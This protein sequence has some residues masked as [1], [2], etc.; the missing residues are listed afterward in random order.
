MG[1]LPEAMVNFLAPARLGARRRRDLRAATSSSPG[2]TSTGISPSPSRFN[3]DKLKWVNQEHLKRLSEAELGAGS[4][5][6]SRGP[7]SISAA[8]PAPGAV[9]MLLR[10]RVATLA[11]M[12]D[13]AHYFYAAPHPSAERLAEHVSAGNRARA[14]RARGGVRGGRLDRARRWARR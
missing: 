10:D 13:A 6:I 14:D 5:R 7:D 8:D 2:S 3:A 4:R 12:A 11:E 9:A 1:Y